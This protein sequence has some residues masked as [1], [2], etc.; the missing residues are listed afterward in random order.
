M[1][2]GMKVLK[3]GGTSV[4]TAESLKNVKKI[5]EAQAE[6]DQLIVV[7][8]ALGGITDKLIQTARTASTG[9]LEYIV[10]YAEIVSRHLQIIKDT[11]AEPLQ[12]EV[13]NEI[14]PLLEEL[15]NIFRGISLIK[16]LSQRTLD[17]VVSYG[18]RLSSRIISKV[19]DN[20]EFFES[21]RFIV[22]EQKHGSHKLLQSATNDRIAGII[23]GRTFSVAVIPG[24][25][26]SDLN[27]DITNLGRGGSDFTAAIVA[28]ALNASSL[29]IWTD[30]NGF[31]TADPRIIPSARVIERLSFAE[32]MELC[33]YG[34]KVIY[35][36]TIYPVFHKNIPTYVK[37]THNPDAEG[38]R[39]ADAVSPTDDVVI[40]GISS[41]NEVALISILGQVASS[42]L[43]FNARVFEGLAKTGVTPLLVSCE[44]GERRAY[45]AVKSCDAE[46]AV[47][48]L[49]D[50]FINE[51][52]GG[53]LSAITVNDIYSAVA[54]VGDNMRGKAGLA[55][56]LAIELEKAGLQPIASTQGNSENKIVY[57]VERNRS[58]ECLTLF[59]SAC[60]E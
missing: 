56:K 43:N 53:T 18:E 58:K 54:L 8:S 57:I 13:R 55:G 31:L 39:I 32:A 5:V 3:F 29:E 60:F 49:T 22:T 37:N 26:S 34:A 14:N 28:S 10:S 27:G 23:G 51:L 16:D 17:V 50:Q 38:T 12:N 41:I 40:K 6:S 7:V 36:P 30:V 59:H 24:F 2:K 46:R 45:V 19:I 42:D 21:T 11:V 44:Y 25:I 35:A 33:N 48:G 20:A 47:D 15:G 4:G 52:R 1:Q 9:N